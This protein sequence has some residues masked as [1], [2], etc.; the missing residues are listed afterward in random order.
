MKI[1]RIISKI[2]GIIL[3]PI[4]ILCRFIL[5]LVK[6]I[7]R[8]ISKLGESANGEKQSNTSSLDYGEDEMCDFFHDEDWKK[9]LSIAPNK[10]N[11]IKRELESMDSEKLKTFKLKTQTNLAK[12]TLQN[13]NT[14]VEFGVPVASLFF[15]IL[16]I[17]ISLH[18]D[19]PTTY[20]A[21]QF[22][23]FFQA[24]VPINSDNGIFSRATN[25]LV[26]MALVIGLMLLG[27][28]CANQ[29]RKHQVFYY[30]TMLNII[31][32]IEEERE[33]SNHYD[34]SVHNTETGETKQFDAHIFPKNK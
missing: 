26:F 23:L 9:E 16:A 34:V 27:G 21:S 14:A 15:S 20:V 31:A 18:P 11:D 33:Q 10:M 6:I 2:Y 7:C 19:E 32:S 22:F 13:R 8:I 1:C 25:F 3:W 29:K 12:A 28:Y 24:I 4:K 5:W 30:Q 17:I